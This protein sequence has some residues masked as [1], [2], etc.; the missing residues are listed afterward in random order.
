MHLWGHNFRGRQSLTI[1][2]DQP[3]YKIMKEHCPLT[4]KMYIE[5]RIGELYAP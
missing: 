4:H 3:L 5:T 2:K 1:S